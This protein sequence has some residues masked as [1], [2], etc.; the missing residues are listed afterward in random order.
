M[1]SEEINNSFINEWANNFKIWKPP[2]GFED[3]SQMPFDYFSSEFIIDCP[4]VQSHAIGDKG[5]RL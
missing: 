5:W 1:I 2:W 4:Q 3:R